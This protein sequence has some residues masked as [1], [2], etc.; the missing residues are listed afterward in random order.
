LVPFNFDVVNFKPKL[1]RSTSKS[2]IDSKPDTQT[3]N[4]T[5]NNNKQEYN[6][7]AGVSFKP[8]HSSDVEIVGVKLGSNSNQD[9]GY[10]NINN[11]NNN[12]NNSNTKKK[13]SFQSKS[14]DLKEKKFLI[15]N[16]FS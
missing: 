3:I 8:T 5:N 13:A 7:L 10:S 15:F 11:N 16:Y 4:K 2:N 12:N 1:L 9:N 6:P 14:Y